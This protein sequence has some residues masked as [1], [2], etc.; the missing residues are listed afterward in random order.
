M[1]LQPPAATS[2]SL[3]DILARQRAAFLRDGPPTL[4]A[5]RSDLLRLK[6]ALKS[7]RR[8]I[9]KAISADFG[10]RSA[11][12]TAILE[13]NPLL[14]GIGYLRHNLARWMRPERRSVALHFLFGRARVEYQPL[15][16]VGIIAPWNFPL[17]L[18]LTPLATAIAAGDRAMVKPSEFTP[19][20][21]ALMADMLAALFPEEQVAVV[22]GGADVAAACGQLVRKENRQRAIAQAAGCS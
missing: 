14:N 16:V 9:E 7:R 13:L 11:K 12:E 22:T 1:N 15:G 10:H 17:S 19:T 5:R 4:D 6:S 18:T 8:E 3:N 2:A 20:T 21:N